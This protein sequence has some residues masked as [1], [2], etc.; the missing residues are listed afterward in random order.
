MDPNT[1]VSE[2][3]HLEIIARLE[4]IELVLRSLCSALD[5][6]RTA[7]PEQIAPL[8]EALIQA[9]SNTPFKP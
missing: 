1:P 5:I 6:Q 7:P 8:T 4:R 2:L 9:L 3:R